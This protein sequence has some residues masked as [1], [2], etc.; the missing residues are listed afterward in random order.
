MSYFPKVVI[1][2]TSGCQIEIHTDVDGGKYLSVAAIQAVHVDSNNSSSGSGLA[3]SASYVGISTSTLGI[4][5]IQVSFYADQNCLLYIQQSGDNINWDISDSYDFRTTDN[6]GITVQ[7]VSSYYRVVVVNNSPVATTVFRLQSLLCPIIEALPRSLNSYG[8]LKTSGGII[9]EETGGRVETDGIG[10]LKTITPVRLVGVSFSGSTLDTNFW[11]ASLTGSASATVGGTLILATGTTASSISR[12]TSVRKANKVPSASNQFRAVIRHINTPASNCVR[13]IGA[14]NSE[15]G[16]FF[17]LNGATL[18]VGSRKAGVDTTIYSGSF[19]G[20]YGKSVVIDTNLR[21]LTIT[22]GS[23]SVKF[24][25]ND[26]LLHTIINMNGLA[27]TN[28][29]SLPCRAEVYNMNGNITNNSSEVRFMCIVRLGELYGN[30]QNAYLGTNAT[31]V[32]K[33]DAGI[34]RRIIVTDNVG[35][36]IAYDSVTGGGTIITSIDAAKVLGSIQF[37]TSF[38]NGLTIVVGSNAKCTVVYE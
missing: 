12:V 8:N 32:L 13:R 14:Y 26:V 16:F 29:L 28:T 27:L 4:A 6:F 22:Y 33:Y 20:N 7:S 21:R 15:E 37:D 18:G 17:E 2:D 36:I 1:Y 34:L 25:I 9:D 35:T 3:A 30:T 19:S 5:G 31:S 38:S 11:S 24:F 10:S 23:Y